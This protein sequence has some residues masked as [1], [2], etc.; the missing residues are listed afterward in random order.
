MSERHII[1]DRLRKKDLEI[2][3][4][5][6]KLKTAR[7]YS[8]ALQDILR[9]MSPQNGE[10]VPPSEP[11]LRPGSTV[12]RAREAIL[13][14]GKPMRMDDLLEALGLDVNRESRASLTSSLSAYVRKGELFTRPAPSTFGLIE[15]AHH[16]T[17][18]VAGDPPSGFGADIPEQPTSDD[19][20][21][22]IPF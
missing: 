4:L 5:E 13:K 10:P 1:E 3:M 15:L 11:V 12:A 19:V 9:L 7:T 14:L 22:E 2:Q 8:Q 20:D 18:Q 17:V 6:E 21:D 16:N